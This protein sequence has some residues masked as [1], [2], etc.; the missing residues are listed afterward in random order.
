MHLILFRSLLVLPLLLA[1]LAG[2]SIPEKYRLEVTGPAPVVF[3]QGAHERLQTLRN[4]QPDSSIA[5]KQWYHR[6]ATQVTSFLHSG[7]VLYNDPVSNYL[8]EV[9]DSLLI[10]EPELRSQ[11]HV[12]TVLDGSP[13]ASV[14][15]DGLV[16]V[17]LGLLARVKSEAELAF[18]LSHEVSHFARN[19]GLR[20]IAGQEDR[21]LEDSPLANDLYNQ[22][23]ER[24][25]DQAGFTRL[26]RSRYSP[27]SALS[28]FYSLMD[29]FP[30]RPLDL[31]W[32]APPGRS[33]SAL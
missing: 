29:E 8:A 23:Q 30:S 22:A 2:Q 10:A 25:A 26:L 18:V 7:K 33:T 24:E 28:V 32:L 19:H 27:S 3:Q 13:N 31:A 21:K 15:P 9:M 17:N 1:S 4:Q 5:I 11:L 20:R 6:T 12:F 14:T 16:M